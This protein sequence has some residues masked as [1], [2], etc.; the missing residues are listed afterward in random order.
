[1]PDTNPNLVRDRAD[2]PQRET[3]NVA[4]REIVNRTRRLRYVEALADAD[5]D[6]SEAT[7]KGSWRDS[8]RFR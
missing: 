7:L 2:A 1:M 8:P 6:L 4:L 3:A 5:V